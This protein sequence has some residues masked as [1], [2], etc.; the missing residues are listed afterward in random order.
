MN[1][2]VIVALISVGVGWCLSQFTEIVRSK[3]RSR[4]LK[5]ALGAELE[6]ISFKLSKSREYC[7]SFAKSLLEGESFN[8]IP[9]KIKTLVH[10]KYYAELY[11]SYNQPERIALS[12]IYGQLEHFNSL[13]DDFDPNHVE[14][15]YMQM[16][17]VIILTLGSIEQFFEDPNKQLGDVEGKMQKIN[18]EIENYS[19]KIVASKIC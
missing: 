19:M 13:I 4:K 1:D 2:K 6:D 16:F 17:Q 7:E 18:N 10:D 8:F 5:S 11:A 9:L 15:Q 14:Q 3:I 12:A